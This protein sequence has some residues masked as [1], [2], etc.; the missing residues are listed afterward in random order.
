MKWYR[1][2]TSTRAVVRISA[3]LMGLPEFAR[4][5]LAHVTRPAIDEKA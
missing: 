3:M 2:Q 4:E 5:V 1:L